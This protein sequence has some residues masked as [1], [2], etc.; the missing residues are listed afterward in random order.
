MKK[1]VLVF[2]AGVG[3]ALAVAISAGK[4]RRSGT[5]VRREALIDLNRGSFEQLTSL[6]LPR[7]LVERILEHRPYRSKLDLVA[8]RVI[9]EEDYVR[10]KSRLRVEDAGE[11]VKIA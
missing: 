3:M 5:P 10:I 11:E 7:D 2:L 4:L 6:G 8:Q 1:S 9:P